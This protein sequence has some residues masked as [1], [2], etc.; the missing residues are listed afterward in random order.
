MERGESYDYSNWNG[1]DNTAAGNRFG[2]GSVTETESKLWRNFGIKVFP[3][4]DG[5][6]IEDKGGGVCISANLL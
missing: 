6:V 3:Y 2:D 5:Y 1:R 4:R